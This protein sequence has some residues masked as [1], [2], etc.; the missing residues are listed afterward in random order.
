MDERMRIINNILEILDENKIPIEIS[1]I[2][3]EF[4]CN[5]Y[6]SKKNSIY[7]IT[8]N[9]KHLSKKSKYNIKYK[10]ITCEGIHVVGVTQFI[11]KVNK[12]SYRCYL[13][14]NKDEEKRQVHSEFLKT[15]VTSTE[16]TYERQLNLLEMKEESLKLFNE[17]DDDFKDTYFKSHLTENDYHRISKNLISLKNGKYN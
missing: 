4:S 5:K 6:S 15:Y 12:C 11:R 10:C 7:H 17:Y 16:V 14:C 9:D 13:C 3:L 1:N 8:L 2:N